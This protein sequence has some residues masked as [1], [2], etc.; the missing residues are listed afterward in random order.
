MLFIFDMGGV[1]TNTFE[2]DRLYSSLNIS[3]KLFFKICRIS[4]TDIWY[5]FEAG[6][7]STKEFWDSFNNNVQFLQ[8]SIKN[9]IKL[10]EIDL[11]D[12]LNVNLSSIPYIKK[13]PFR[14]HFHPVLNPITADLIK[15]LRKK[16][17]VVCGTNTNQSHW[18]NHLERGDYALFDQTYASNKIGLVKP[19]T[20]FFSAI[21]E[22]EGFSPE[23]TFF[24]DD[25]IENCEAASKT[26]INSV[27]F[28]SAENLFNQWKK[29]F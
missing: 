4:D 21:L 9:G 26:G 12:L 3:S 20:E 27:H 15:N 24:T 23:E 5:N 25:K 19:D 2:M 1:V 11:E 7:I 14:L 17:R 13:D 8:N 6:Y 22:A 29:Y 28:I 18:E 16:H 10:P